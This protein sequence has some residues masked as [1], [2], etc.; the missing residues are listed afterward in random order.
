MKTTDF[1]SFLH[2]CIMR[3]SVITVCSFKVTENK[4]DDENNYL[5]K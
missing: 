5:N 2:F 1:L 4:T 3:L